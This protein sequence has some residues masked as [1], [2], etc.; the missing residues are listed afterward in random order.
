MHAP[1]VRVV[2]VDDHSAVSSA[3]F[4]GWRRHATHLDATRVT[5]LVRDLFSIPTPLSHFTCLLRSKRI[6]IG[7]SVQVLQLVFQSATNEESQERSHGIDVSWVGKAVLSYL[8]I[9][10]AKNEYFAK[11]TVDACKTVTNHSVMTQAQL[12][13]DLPL[14]HSRDH[15]L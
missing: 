3:S 12:M 2:F 10:G 1:S 6:I 14:R 9:V 4:S 5:V 8:L 7:C 13:Q 11:H 15:H